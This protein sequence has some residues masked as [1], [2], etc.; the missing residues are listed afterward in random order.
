MK[1]RNLLVLLLTVFVVACVN[2]DIDS[3]NKGDDKGEVVEPSYPDEP[4]YIKF[5]CKYVFADYDGG[6]RTL[7]VDVN[8]D[9]EWEITTSG[10]WFSAERVENDLVVTFSE[11]E[12]KLE[13][14]GAITVKVGVEENI[15]ETSVSVW[16]IGTDT[17]ELIYEVETTEPN[18]RVIAAPILTYQNGGKMTADFGDGR[19]SATYENQRVY[20]DYEEPGIYTIIISGENI[21][22][23][24]FSDGNHICPELKRI[25]SWG[26]MGYKNALNMCKGCVNLEEIPNDVAGSFE[27]V[28]NFEATFLGCEKLKEIPAGLFRHAVK[29][30]KFSNCFRYTSSLSEIPEELFAN[31]PLAEEFHHTFYGA[32]TDFK[33]TDESLKINAGDYLTSYPAELE[34]S[35]ADGKLRAVPAA[36]FGNCPNATRFE[37]VFAATAIESVPETIFVANS[38]VENFQGTF[39]ACMNLQSIPAKLME[40][41]TA[42]INIKYMFAGCTSL[43]E[44]P[45]AMFENC[46]EVTNLEA[47]FYMASGIKSAKRGVFKGLSKV[48]TIGSVF[49]GCASLT[50]VEAGVF[51]GL[52]SAKSFPYC[53]ADCTSLRSIPE[54]LLAGMSAAYE[55]ESMFA[56]TAL[57]SVPEGL[58]DEVRDYDLG[59]YAY[60]F[61]ECPNLKTVPA[62]LFDHVTEASSGGFNNI[63]YK[64]GIETIP[65][66]LFVTCTKV[67]S[68]SFEAVFMGCPELHT[69]EGSIF[70]EVTT[71]TSMKQIFYNCPKLVNIPADLFK[72]F[73][74]A[75]LKFTNA[76]TGC[77]ALKSLPEGLFSTC[78]KAT[79]FTCT[80]ADCTSLESIPENLL[81]ACAEVTYVDGMFVGCTAL[82]T[83]PES[84]F[85]NSPKIGT[86][87]ETFAECTALESIPEK[88]FSAL[89]GGT[90]SVTFSRCFYGCSALKS[91]PAGLFDAARRIN[92]IDNCFNGCTAI[93]GESPYTMIGE[94][95]VHLYERT[96]GTDFPTIPSNSTAHADCFAGCEGLSD[97]TKMPSAWR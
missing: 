28:G 69:V 31:S 10:E 92:Y 34:Q 21:H 11:S 95:K 97:Y 39:Y 1:I 19:E 75:K 3:G 12:D 15:A 96:K 2:N 26:K 64:S 17:E 72:P 51:E 78:T 23:L 71:I 20:K 22:N 27:N 84:L 49:Q 48:K 70:P 65:A 93:T 63:F 88:L 89:S 14:K 94:K 36:L 80:F 67:D 77:T 29:A 16:Q 79:H 58:F 82:K 35:I 33:I 18:Q 74:T 46:T 5:G 55:F 53:F 8:P 7:A 76:F 91:I 9:W 66:G 56:N 44:I 45:V 4:A 25:H 86:F 42:A 68:T 52:T 73:S 59:D 60:I 50:D 24:E 54:G 90:K 37:Y 40:K 62:K 81:S 43:T 83:I 30:K 87:E 61:A 41:A 32:G 13:R 57:E 6:A 38:K 85:A 47:L